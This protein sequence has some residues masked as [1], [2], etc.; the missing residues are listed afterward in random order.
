MAEL[1]YAE[2]R[3]LVIDAWW[4]GGSAARLEQLRGDILAARPDVIVAQGGSALAPML[5]ASV[6]RPVLFSMSGDP[7]AAKI[8]ESYARPGGRASGITLFAAELTGK[9]MAML[10]EVLPG[11]RSI[12]V[13]AN[14]GHPG[15]PRELQSSRD[16][17]A[18]LGLALSYHPTTSVAE[19]EPALD[20]IAQARIDAILVFADGFAL[21]QAE[22]IAAFSLRE[23]IPVAAGWAPFAQRGNL[24]SYGPEFT[25]VYRRLANYADRVHKGARAGD[26]PIEQPTRFELVVNLKTAR[27]IGIKV[28]NSLLLQADVVIE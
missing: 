1:G 8:A 21:G 9:R 2:G 25:D 15:A 10:K 23:R 4:G 14:P 5:H 16:A 22:R 26:L 13:I 11:M 19:L 28:P 17:A 12:A 27:A 24:L 6:D 7:V 20:K 3:N 18:R